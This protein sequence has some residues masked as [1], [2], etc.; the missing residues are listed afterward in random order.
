MFIQ[1]LSSSEST[2]REKKSRSWNL[3][4]NKK[5]LCYTRRSGGKRNRILKIKLKNE[6]FEQWCEAKTVEEIILFY[7]IRILHRTV[8]AHHKLKLTVKRSGPWRRQR[9]IF[10]PNDFL[11]FWMWKY[12]YLNEFS[13]RSL[14]LP[15][16]TFNETTNLSFKFEI[17]VEKGQETALSPQKGESKKKNKTKKVCRLFEEVIKSWVHFLK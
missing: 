1:L 11:L 10:N 8:P 15:P 16:F 9:K 6:I 4:K 17:N 14:R 13:I 5:K 12:F 7:E 3:N 2:R